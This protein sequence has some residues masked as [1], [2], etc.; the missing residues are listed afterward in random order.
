MA[1]LTENIYTPDTKRAFEN[2]I[3]ARRLGT[4]ADVAS[5]I[6]YLASEP[7]AYINGVM[8]AVNGGYL[9]AG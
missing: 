1:S 5:A 9:A 4:V 6:A 7:A 3:P 2:M 8:L